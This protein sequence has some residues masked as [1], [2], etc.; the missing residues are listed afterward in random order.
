MP[1]NN[2]VATFTVADLDVK[3][4]KITSTTSWSYNPFKRV[5]VD[6]VKANTTAR[7]LKDAGADVLL[8]PEYIVEKRGFLRGGSV[9]VTGFPANYKN[10]HKITPEEAEILKNINA[11]SS[12]DKKHKKFL[13]F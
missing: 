7:M 10:F 3:K 13:F 9:T 6:D 11:K 1:V 2:T 12:K 8:E 5:S 4:Q